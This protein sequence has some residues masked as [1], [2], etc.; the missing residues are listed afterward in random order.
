MATAV[1]NILLLLVAALFGILVVMVLFLR[2]Q[3]MDKSPAPAASVATSV[4]AS[5]ARS[6]E[7]VEQG[8]LLR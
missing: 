7:N 6:P 3:I 8:E 1:L 5:I 2:D 4:A